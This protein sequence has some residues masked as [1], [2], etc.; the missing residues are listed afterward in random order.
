MF[1][2]TN[3]TLFRPACFQKTVFRFV[4]VGETREPVHRRWWKL[5]V[6]AEPTHTYGTNGR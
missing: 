1:W 3:L 4:T 2:T 5:A 6:T